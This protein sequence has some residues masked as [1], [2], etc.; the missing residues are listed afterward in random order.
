MN[1]YD[2]SAV[3]Y[4]S[5]LGSEFDGGAFA[6]HDADG[7]TPLSPTAGTLLTFSAGGENPHSAG[8][9]HAGARFALACWFTYDPSR[10]VELS[11]PLA[12]AE[13]PTHPLVLWSAD[14]SMASAAACCLAS[15][16]PLRAAIEE[17]SAKGRAVNTAAPAL[18]SPTAWL[19]RLAAS[20]GVP[21]HPCDQTCSRVAE[22]A[23][24]VDVTDRVAYGTGAAAPVAG[25]GRRGPGDT[26]Q[27]E[28][29]AAV[30]ARRRALSQARDLVAKQQ[31]Q[32]AAEAAEASISHD[33]G[34]DVFD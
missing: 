21:H 28:L 18:P 17:A 14:R 31:Q 13:A 25:G 1:F 27:E 15:N 11:P 32:Q 3:L 9:V 4:L 23:V 34:F 6:F 10:A 19:Q 16:D 30:E 22:R 24:A 20:G 7:D 8:R 2:V 29:R 12:P 33:D 26:W 5:T